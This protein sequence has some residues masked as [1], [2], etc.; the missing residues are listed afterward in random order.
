MHPLESSAAIVMNG[1]AL[2][3]RMARDGYLYLPDVLPR[4]V[5]AGVQREIA[6]IARRGGVAPEGCALG[7]CRRPE[8]LVLR[9]PRAALP[10][11]P[12]P[13]QPA[14][15]L[16]CAQDHPQLI[17]LFERLL[18]PGLPASP[19]ADAEHL[20]RA[21]RVHDQGAPGL[22]ERAGT[23]EVDTAWIPLIDCPSAMG[24]APCRARL[25]LRACSSSASATAQ[26]ASR[27]STPWRIGGRAARC[28]PGTC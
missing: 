3:A 6:V 8:P 10:G 16:P 13:D 19:R 4:D 28:A 14:R 22:P 11:G 2:A 18:G 27:S 17:G 7:R 1:A 25:H 5:V 24:G 26:G 21:A 9:R 12:A 23:T 15:A 20:P